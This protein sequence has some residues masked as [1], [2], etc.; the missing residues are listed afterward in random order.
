M[1]KS[2]NEACILAVLYVIG[3]EIACYMHSF[4]VFVI[5]TLYVATL[6]ACSWRIERLEKR[7]RYYRRELNRQIHDELE[8]PELESDK[9][10][11][12]VT[13][14]GKSA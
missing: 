13:K 4:A 2:E 8:Q 6:L 5:V 14:G 10:E 11:V 12:K 7:I 9:P 1:K 3:F